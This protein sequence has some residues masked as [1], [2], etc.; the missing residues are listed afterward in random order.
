MIKTD[1]NQNEL[2]RTMK[3][4][5]LFMI[6]IGG[7]I[8]TGLFL[9]SGYT[10]NQAGPGGA[11]L[12][13]IL[14]G[15]LMYLVMLCLG[16]LSVAMPVA[17]SFQAYASKYIGPAT[18]FTV[19]WLYWLNWAM[20]VGI[21]FTAAGSLMKRWFPETPIWIWCVLFGL[22]LLLLNVISVRFYAEAEFWFASIKVVTIL[23]FIIIGGASMFGLIHFGN[24]PAPMFSHFT[25]DGGLFP[26]GVAAV[27]LTMIAVNFAFQ[28]TELVGVT[29][30]ESENPEKDIPKA[31]NN[32]VWRILFFYVIS[33]VI[34]VGLF[35]WREAGLLESPFV[36]VFE[37]IGIPYA[38]D[39]MNFVL[40][41]SVLSVGNSGLYAAS[42][43]L[44]G[45]SRNKLA[46][47]FLGKLTKNGTPINALLITLAVA[48]LSLL[49]SVFA[50]DTV[51]LWLL[52]VAGMAGVVVWMAIAAS[53]FMFRKRFLADGGK[54]E[55]L[56]FHTPLYPFVPIAA[57]LICAVILVS[58]VFIPDQRMAIYCGV[59][60]TVGCYVFYFVRQ[61]KKTHVEK[62]EKVELLQTKEAK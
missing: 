22:L 20:T 45:M 2:K 13:Y 16:E 32:T 44:W 41:T 39:I 36:A 52:S 58:L 50:E 43:M 4:R 42:R 7:V 21:E 6:S 27:L 24:E 3:S 18:G 25:D 5:H 37:K 26:N 9:G 8:G 19:G 30:G 55:E 1:G 11:I 56:K 33:M 31:V 46:S 59:P 40:L 12:A 54:L 53:Q 60:F 35:P 62:T 38:T 15:L 14:G 10:I 61:R 29:A 17:G 34:L 28:G 49:S 51:Y 48:W 57:F 47:P 23:L